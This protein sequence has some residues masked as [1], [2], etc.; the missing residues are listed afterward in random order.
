MGSTM[1]MLLEEA[2]LWLDFEGAEGEALALVTDF[3]IVSVD[4]EA[5]VRDLRKLRRFEVEEGEWLLEE[6]GAE[7]LHL[8]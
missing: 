8:K 5:M 7:A 4:C 1:R 6:E 2:W 3:N